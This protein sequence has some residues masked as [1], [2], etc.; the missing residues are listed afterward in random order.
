MSFQIAESIFL[1]E[2]VSQNLLQKGSTFNYA[3][4]TRPS[5]ALLGEFNVKGR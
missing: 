2:S 1:L 3:T 4:I 5:E